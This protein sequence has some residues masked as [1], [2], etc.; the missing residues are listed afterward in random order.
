M[1]SFIWAAL[2]PRLNRCMHTVIITC[3]SVPNVLI[4]LCTGILCSGWFLINNCMS[5]FAHQNT[6]LFISFG[7]YTSD[8]H[9]FVQNT[10]IC[11]YKATHFF[12]CLIVAFSYHSQLIMAGI[13]LRC[14]YKST[15]FIDSSTQFNGNIHK[16]IICN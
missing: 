9:R 11:S 12:L 15:S 14:S 4:N 10:L 2:F 7:K 8:H 5:V 3:Q 16:E 1:T 13:R 6:Y